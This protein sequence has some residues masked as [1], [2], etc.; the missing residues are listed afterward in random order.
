MVLY[1]V[2][3]CG[4]MSCRTY[5]MCRNSVRESPRIAS[6]RPASRPPI[7]SSQELEN[8]TLSEP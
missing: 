2:V 8:V 4:V 6:H 1:G 5:G 7:S 3:R